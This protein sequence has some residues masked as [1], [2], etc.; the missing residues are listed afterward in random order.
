[1]KIGPFIIT[2]KRS[3]EN[4]AHG[5]TWEDV[6]GA[7]RSQSGQD[8]T[9]QN[10]MKLSAA[11]ACVR[12]LSESIASLSWMVYERLPGG[13]KERATMHPV[14]SLL[15]DRPNAIMSSFSFR[16]RMMMDILLSGNFYALIEWDKYGQVSGLWPLNPQ[17]VTPY[18]AKDG[19]NLAYK[20][21]SSNGFDGEYQSGNIFHVPAMGDGIVGKS[22]IS[23][24]ADTF[25][26]ALSQEL[27]ASTYYANG[28]HPG[29]VIETEKKINPDDLARLKV[30]WSNAYGR[31]DGGANWHKVAVLEDGLKWKP[32]TVSPKDAM[33]LESRRFQISDIA[34][35][36][37]VPPHL[38]GDLEKATFSNI[39]HQSL[40]FVTHALRPWCVRIEQEAN[41]KLFLRDEWDGIFTEFLLDSMLR[42]DI[43]SRNEAYQIMRRNGVLNADEWRERE[44]LNP[45]PNE[46]GKKYIVERNMQELAQIGKEP[47]K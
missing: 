21:R 24:A 7:T 14:Y 19:R 46:Q 34:R 28:A 42:G 5:I 36:F 6:W 25:G 9:R 2:T 15:H 18:I 26:I 37:R 33:I 30:G 38:I 39:E 35:V 40:D 29:G 8:V 41:H 4:P 3:L 12:V 47:K 10:V 43:K 17:S 16:E 1:M 31:N 44:N 45:L 32:M 11:L 13:G 23:Y 20:I 22:I 27:F